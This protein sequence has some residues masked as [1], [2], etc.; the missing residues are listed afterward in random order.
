LPAAL[1][2][3]SPEEERR[4]RRRKRRTVRT[5]LGTLKLGGEEEAF[6]MAGKEEVVLAVSAAVSVVSLA[7]V[8]GLLVSVIPEGEARGG[9]PHG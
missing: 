3:V 2:L 1:V 5:L 4:R 6:V 9:T 8:L 7:S